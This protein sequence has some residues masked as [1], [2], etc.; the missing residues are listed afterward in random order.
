MTISKPERAA[1]IYDVAKVA[2]VS[3]QTVSRLI[4]GHRISDQ[5]RLVVEQAIAELDFRPN[6]AA[7]ALAT[8]RS[9]RIGALAYEMT[10]LGPMT[11]LSSAT[12]A[13]RE[14]GFFVDIVT[15]DPFD[16][17][18]TRAAIEVINQ[19]DL[20][21]ILA[22]APNDTIRE[23]LKVTNFRVPVYL[24]DERDDDTHPDNLS[25]GSGV[26]AAEH[27]VQL[28]HR[29]LA[30]VSG[31]QDWVSARMRE[32]G[33]KA[34]LQREGLEPPLTIEGDWSPQSGFDAMNT[35]LARGTRV[36]GVFAANDQMA[37][38]VMA[39]ATRAGL[40]VPH[41]LSVVG[42]D[43][44]VEG[45][46]LTPALTTVPMHFA[47]QGRRVFAALLARING[48]TPT[49][50]EHHIPTQLIVRESTTSPSF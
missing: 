22:F 18:S 30:H 35:L 44:V 3:H 11:L 7:R 8:R 20:A 45:P 17:E 1:T 36:T 10:Q 37:I 23:A 16:S 49:E 4:K 32:R 5:S 43:D 42:A 31:P 12:A 33:F 2:G 48:D 14:A 6:S 29:S 41:D 50:N 39:A 15:M 24:E 21:G 13:A 34:V 9:M 46:F 28:G 26:L 19:H 40:N 25:Y 47:D 27:L 38:G